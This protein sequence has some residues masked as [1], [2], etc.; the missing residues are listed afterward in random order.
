MNTS[1]RPNQLKLNQ[2]A[3]E[4]SERHASWLELFYDLVFVV[5]ISTLADHLLLSHH[6]FGVLRYIFSFLLI[7]WLWIGLSYYADQFDIEDKVGH[8]SWF[9]AMFGIIVLNKFLPQAFAGEGQAFALTYF[10]MRCLL[11]GLYLRVYFKLHP[12]SVLLKKYITGFS[13]GALIWLI[14]IFVPAEVSWIVWLFAMAVDVMTPVF[15]YFTTEQIAAQNSHMDERFGLFVIIVLG[16][17]IIEVA[18][19]LLPMTWSW[20]KLAV[21]VIGFLI[22]ISFWYQYFSDNDQKVIHKAL[23]SDRKKL[24]LSFVYGYSHLFIFMSIVSFG[25]GLQ[26]FIMQDLSFYHLGFWIALSSVFIFFIVN[27]L[28][29]WSARQVAS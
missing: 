29:R 26:L 6:W 28:I 8:F 1:L 10:L 4:P 16:E 23:R 15:A 22:A 9:L 3:D 19:S 25:V 21:V 27:R 20:P 17:T 14:S 12:R 5:T 24:L 18:H 13:I 7:W 2:A 11:I